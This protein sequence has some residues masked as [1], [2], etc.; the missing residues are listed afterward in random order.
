MRKQTV[1]MMQRRKMMTHLIRSYSHI[2]RRRVKKGRHLCQTVKE[3]KQRA[4]RGA[5][6]CMCSQTLK[7]MQMK[8][9]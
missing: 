9:A 7:R 1:Q 6:R 8:P 5:D 3:R 2:L 4:R